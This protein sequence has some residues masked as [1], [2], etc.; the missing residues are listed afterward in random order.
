MAKIEIEYR[1]AELRAAT[2]VFEVDG[3]AVSYNKPSQ[4]LGGFVESL[5]RGC[6][7]D[8][9]ESGSEVKCLVNT[10]RIKCSVAR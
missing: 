3:R 2:A 4:D 10:T 1:R 8:S 7:T 6:F 5:Q 9:L